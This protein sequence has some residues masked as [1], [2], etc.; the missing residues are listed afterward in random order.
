MIRKTC[1]LVRKACVKW[2]LSKV[3]LLEISAI[4]ARG[5]MPSGNLRNQQDPTQSR[6]GVYSP[7]KKVLQGLSAHIGPPRMLF[8]QGFSLC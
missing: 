4:K 1:N 5:K 6:W 3:W 8:S 7:E 2:G